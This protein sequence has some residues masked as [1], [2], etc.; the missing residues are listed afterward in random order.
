MKKILL[1]PALAVLALIPAMQAASEL[2]KDGPRIDAHAVER[3]KAMCATLAGA[4]AFSFRS[5]SVL[6]VPATTGQLLTVFSTAEV[7][8]QRPDKIHA[9]LGGEAPPFE[10]FYDGETVTAFAP[11]TKAY[12]VAKAPPTI[13]AM[14]PSLVD[15]TGIRFATAPL[16]FSD[17]FRVLGRGLTSAVVVGPVVIDG[18]ACEHLAFRAPGVNWEVWIESGD[19]ALPRRLAVTFTDR[20]DFQRTLVGFSHWNLHPGS[21]LGGDQNFVFHKPADAREVPFLTAMKAAGR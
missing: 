2:P 16:F 14:M 20:P 7:S 8:L 18:A 1:I 17:P 21:W 13:D 11:A 4:P 6:E 9:K 10:F 12:S 19:R 5:R 15:E 3:L